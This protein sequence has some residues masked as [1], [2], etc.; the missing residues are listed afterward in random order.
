M[1]TLRRGVYTP[2]ELHRLACRLDRRVVSVDQVLIAMRKGE[3]LHLQYEHGR[4]LWSLSNGQSVSADVAEILTK[5][6]S[7]V[8][9]SGALFSDMPGQTWR[10][11]R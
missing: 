2:S 5:N 10:F 3:V 11:D 9:A 1:T 4:P 6:A 8:P 7:V